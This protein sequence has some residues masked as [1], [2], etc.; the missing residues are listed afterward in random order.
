[1]TRRRLLVLI[2]C[3]LAGYIHVRAG[4]NLVRQEG[5]ATG[6]ALGVGEGVAAAG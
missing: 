1:M 2:V 6:R 4:F 5:G 3:V